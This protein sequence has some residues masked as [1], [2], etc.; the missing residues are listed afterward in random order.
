[1]IIGL[2]LGA[3]RRTGKLSW[4]LP[5]AANF[6]LRQYGLML[7]LAAGQ[8]KDQTPWLSPPWFHQH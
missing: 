2:I 4:K 5:A 6:T 8:K 7:F 1:M 3:L